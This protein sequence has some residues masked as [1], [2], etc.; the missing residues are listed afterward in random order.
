MKLLNLPLLGVPNWRGQSALIP[1]AAAPP[2]AAHPPSQSRA[3]AR[4]PMSWDE[5][6]I[7]AVIIFGPAALLWLV[8]DLLRAVPR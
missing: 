7:L 5:L 2:P 6:V 1:G 3:R 8:L 4:Y